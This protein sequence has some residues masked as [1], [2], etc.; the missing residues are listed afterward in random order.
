MKRACVPIL[1][2]CLAVLLLLPACGGGKAQRSGT[3]AGLVYS[4]SSRAPS[5]ITD[6]PEKENYYFFVGSSADSDSYDTGKKSAL[7]DALSQVVGMIGVKVSSS[8]TIE[9]RY[10]AEQYETTISAEL[11]SEGKARLRDAE[12]QEI[13]YERHRKPDGREIFRVWVLL[14]YGKREIQNEQ[15]RLA[16]IL[17]LKYGEVKRLEDKAS[18]LIEQGM[19]FDAVVARLNA[20]SAA[21]SVDDGQLLFERNL[22]GAGELLAGIR[23]RKFGEDQIGWVGKPLGK[24]LRLQ[25][26]SLRGESEVPVPNVPVRFFYRVPRENNEGYK[27]EVTDEVTDDDGFASYSVQMVHEVS[28]SNRVEAR[29]NMEPFIRQLRSAP[30]ALSERVKVLE[31]IAA[32]KR[33]VYLFGSDTP[34][35]EIRTAVYFIQL[36]EDGSLI[37]R[38]V[39]AP[40]V[41]EVLFEKQ[42]N[43][44]LLDF[45]QIDP[46]IIAARQD[47][48]VL[49]LIRA[50]AGK[51][52]RRV[53]LGTVRITG[54]D[55]VSGFHTAQA[56]ATATLYDV[57]GGGIVRTWQVTASATGRTRERAGLNALSE[58]GTS[59]GMILSRTIP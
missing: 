57:Q 32:G 53:L 27:Y 36:D 56:L 30:G 4:S 17:A 6:I 19:Y 1:P 20:A 15:K 44:E 12:I 59:L 28:D 10:F 41:Y 35:R 21:L 24:P 14:K 42:F 58:S 40:S 18:R 49:E 47:E 8:S 7:N 34:A 31:D 26:Y 3:E 33:T 48:A 29:L 52:V 23:F 22:V 54:Y 37:S 2:A 11:Q 25:A 38:P 46:E 55:M 39:S 43:I 13:Y 45:R 9:E 51:G 16:D 5:W 50:S